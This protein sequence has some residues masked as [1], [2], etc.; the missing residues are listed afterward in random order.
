M[1]YWLRIILGVLVLP[2][3]VVLYLN[4]EVYAAQKGWDR[5]LLLLDPRITSIATTPLALALS[6]FV[7]GVAVGVWIYWAATKF[8]RSREVAKD[9]VDFGLGNAWA[10][11]LR[12]FAIRDAAAAFAG[13]SPQKWSESGRAQAIT[14][15]LLSQVSN[16]SVG[17]PEDYIPRGDG[18]NSVHPVGAPVFGPKPSVTIGTIVDVRGLADYA[19]ERDVEFDWLLENDVDLIGS[20]RRQALEKKRSG[21]LPPG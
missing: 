15:D 11:G 4:I 6:A 8:D 14:V 21:E 10:R 12:S 7:V 16:G 13:I 1:R 19:R 2:F 20:H 3:T 17:T 9:D 5:L 18:R